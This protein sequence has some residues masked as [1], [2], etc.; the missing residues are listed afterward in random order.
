MRALYRTRKDE[1]VEPERLHLVALELDI[2]RQLPGE[3][4]DRA[5]QLGQALA[6]GEMGFDQVAE[7]L[8]PHARQV[9][10]GR[11]TRKQLFAMGRNVEA[12]VAALEPG[13]SSPLVQE[14]Q[15][16]YLLHLTAATPERQLSFAEAVP[17]L[18]TA[19]IRA[20]QRQLEEQVRQEILAEQHLE[21]MP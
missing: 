17:R 3:F 10:L 19:L 16:L 21:V 6:A 9:D 4:Y 12:A 11:M 18:R 2:D 7:A 1:L 14:G 13:R 5:H 8:A 20:S 15:T